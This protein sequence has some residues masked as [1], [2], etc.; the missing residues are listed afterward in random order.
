MVSSLINITISAANLV[1]SKCT[2]LFLLE[3]NILRYWQRWEL[4]LRGRTRGSGLTRFTVH[5][6]RNDEET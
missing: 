5:T 2:V 3:K 1:V 4:S 6:H